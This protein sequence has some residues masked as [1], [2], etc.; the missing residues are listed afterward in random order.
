MPPEKLA[1]LLFYCL[2]FLAL[3]APQARAFEPFVVSDIKVVGLQRISEGA[4]FNEFPVNTGD[5]MDDRRAAEALHA[6]YKT[7]FF[8]DV[9][10]SR[11]GDTIVITVEERP[12]IDNITF[13]GNKDITTEQLQEAL[14]RIGLAK[15]RVFNP[16][17][18]DQV[19]GELQR[20]YFSHGK[21]GVKIKSE[22]TPLERNRVDITITISE[23]EVAK[24]ASITLVGNKVFDDE[25]LLDTFQLSTPTLFSFFSESDQYSRPKLTADLETLR[26]WY[27]D[28][29]YINFGIDS[30]QV[31]ITPDKKNVYITINITEG[32]RFTIKGVKL[33]GELIVAEEELAK[34]ITLSPGDT[35]SRRKASDS[36]S[37]ISE[38][39]GDEGYAFTNV[40]TVPDIDLEHKEVTLTFFVDPGRRV[41][42]RRLGIVG[43][44]KTK[45]EVL[46]RELRQ[47]EGGWISTDKVNRSRVRL[48]RL[49][50]FEGIN[51]ETPAVP[52]VND[53]VDVNLSVKE[54]PA[55]TL[56]AGVGYSD[57]QGI[58][59]NASIS[60]N[61]FFGT[62]KR[63]SA[64][65]NN[66]A[67]NQIYSFGYTN[68]YYTI[69]GISRGF[70]F[71]SRKTDAAQADVGD[72]FSNVD[73]GS[74]NYGFPIDE[75]QT[76]RLDF[77]LERT[78]ITTNNNTPQA[79]IDFLNANTNDFDIIKMSTTWSYDT[80]NR[81]LLADSGMLQSFSADVALPGSGLT[82]YK[83]SSRTRWYT[84]L[85][86]KLTILMKGDIGYGDS[87]SDTTE[88]P[89]FEHYF[90]GGSQSVRGYKSNSLGPRE[91][92]KALGGA[93]KVVGGLELIIPPPFTADVE[94]FRLSGFF[95]IGNVFTTAADFD[96]GELR[97]SA[98]IG[99]IWLS[100]IGP[101]TFSL[102]KA[103]NDKPGDR[104][105][106]FQFSLGA[107]Y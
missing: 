91:L 43:N 86:G 17:S 33:D 21:Y 95:D 62:G 2:L 101:L 107:F 32:D 4:V 50:Y 60:Q 5:T 13:S 89:F 45:D 104:T 1:R 47:M 90:A 56:T 10:L 15:G 65:V 102:A 22:V 75:N 94:S 68:P 79:Y 88:L 97:Y 82:Y 38:R 31:S 61:N 28:R 23:G 26:S 77:G 67:V 49:G 19:E 105:Q 87:Y 42:V 16:S 66:S 12:A 80:R 6:L 29:G 81:T 70:E 8:K 37:K 34:L 18:L 63:V 78:Q 51:V 11:E 84:P 14:E 46:R 30:T 85:I 69:D 100:P 40:N 9:K 7:G 3:I 72:Y 93:L 35:F 20:Q 53:Q 64:T 55:G 48:Q 24:I 44:D 76:L 106:N 103:L 57:A 58:L 96:A 54:R 36:A 25:T 99:A 83:V 74:V 27:L 41:Y 59:F 52:G 39:L 92:D 98:G 73:Q 71:S